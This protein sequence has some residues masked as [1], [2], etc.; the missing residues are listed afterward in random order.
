MRALALA[1]A[2]VVV[3]SAQPT[4]TFKSK[5][6]GAC[7]LLKDG[8]GISSKCDVSVNTA[9]GKF[10]VQQ[11][12]NQIEALRK[13]MT[14]LG[15][16]VADLEAGLTQVAGSVQSLA[17]DLLTHKSATS[18]QVA[19]VKRE[20]QDAIARISLTPGPK[21]EMGAAGARGAAGAPGRNGSN[22]AAGAKGAKGESGK[23]ALAPTVSPNAN[24]M[25]TDGGST[26]MY[27][28]GSGRLVAE[29]SARYNNHGVWR[30]RK[31]C[32]GSCSSSGA[33]CSDHSAWS[34]SSNLVSGD[35]VVWYNVGSGQVLDCAWGA[36]TQQP[37]PPP[38]GH[39]GTPYKVHKQSGSSG[40]TIRFGDKIRFTRMWH[41]SFC[42][43][44]GLTC[45]HDSCDGV[46]GGSGTTFTVKQHG[47]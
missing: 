44:C 21:G 14:A 34:C 2:V 42:S 22:G 10:S 27:W 39:W 17:G 20:L 19:Q 16:R 15:S 12:G 41:G 40:S 24:I 5:D 6:G 7:V 8:G 29:S 11:N 45:D 43:T 26:A 9:Y 4:L 23:A 36:C 25:L 35:V 1:L 37:F 32:G 47:V 18:T 30:L 13:G 33:L 38:C 3:L 28:Q 31:C 46:H